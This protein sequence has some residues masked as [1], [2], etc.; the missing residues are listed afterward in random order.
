[1]ITLKEIYDQGNITGSGIAPAVVKPIFE[2]IRMTRIKVREAI[3]RKKGSSAIIEGVEFPMRFEIN[4][5]LLGTIHNTLCDVFI[6][7][8][9]DDLGNENYELL[10][11]IPTEVNMHNMQNYNIYSRKIDPDRLDDEDDDYDYQDDSEDD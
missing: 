5:Q 8:S 4:P 7:R 11:T 10:S 2:D 9:E 1:M 6:G 3:Y